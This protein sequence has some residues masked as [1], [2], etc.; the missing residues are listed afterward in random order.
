M[1]SQK[2][3]LPSFELRRSDRHTLCLAA[4]LSTSLAHRVREAS[5]SPRPASCTVHR[6]LAPPDRR[7]TPLL[8][9]PWLVVRTTFSPSPSPSPST[10]A[11]MAAGEWEAATCRRVRRRD[12]GVRAALS[13]VEERQERA[14]T[15]HAQG[16]DGGMRETIIQQLLS[17]QA[18]VKGT[19]QGS[20]RD[21]DATTPYSYGCFIEGE[22]L[23]AVSEGVETTEQP[24]SHSS[25][26][27][28][29][30]R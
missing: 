1:H 3:V 20:S 24:S 9:A 18:L 30:A 22:F 6:Q 13:S 12:A 5:A 27:A 4:L 7:R 26:F 15:G 23:L 28:L 2:P 29:Q 11:T 19:R 10:I 16:T 25:L 17:Q 14:F 21:L 8:V